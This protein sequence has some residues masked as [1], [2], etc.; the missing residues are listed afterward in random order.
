MVNNDIT[1]ARNEIMRRLASGATYRSIGISLGVN[2][3]IVWKLHKDP[4]YRPTKATLRKLKG[5]VRTR[6][7]LYS[8][9]VAGLLWMLENRETLPPPE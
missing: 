3:G 9:P 8:Y 7:D 5:R 4:R 2:R 6:P 1:T